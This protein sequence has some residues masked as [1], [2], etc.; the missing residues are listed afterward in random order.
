MSQN[1]GKERRAG[2]IAGMYQQIGPY[3]GLGTQLAASVIVFL[4][5]GKWIDGQL[6]T[7]PIFLLVG[8]FTGAVGG[9]YHFIKTVIQIGER[10]RR[11]QAER[12]L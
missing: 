4:F 11:E 7:Y 8:A 12:N 5:I 2:D 6:G 10:K 1:D 9:F 3:L